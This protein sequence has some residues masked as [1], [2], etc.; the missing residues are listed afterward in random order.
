[1]A[2]EEFSM[3][4]KLAKLAVFPAFRVNET[5]IETK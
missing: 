1:M 2:E 4:D 3:T 5:A